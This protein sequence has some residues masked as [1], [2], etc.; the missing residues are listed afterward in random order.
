MVQSIVIVGAGIIGAATALQLAKAGHNVRVISDGR[1]DATTSAFGWINASFYLD[2]DH[3]HLRVA[4]IDAWR[5]L[6]DVVPLSVTW[7]GCLCWDMPEPK[8]RETY[9]TLRG[10]GYPVEMLNQDQI[11]LLEPSLREVPEMALLFPNEGAAHSA[12]I[13]K[14]LLRAAQ[15]VGAQILRNVTVKRVKMQGGRTIGVDTSDGVIAADQVILAAGTGTAALAQSADI[16]IP[17]VPR[18]AYIL[19]TSPQPKVLNHILA[20]PNGEIRQEPSGQLLMPVAV[21]H[22]ED[23]AEALTQT[24]TEAADGAIDRLRGLFSGMDDVQWSEVLRAERPVPVDNYPVVGSIGEGLYAA[25]L[26]SGITLGPLIAEL[27]AKEVTDGPDNA[28]AALLAAYRPQRF[29][30]A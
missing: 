26:H 3:H 23:A 27:I 2:D 9:N 10:F 20:A 18:P 19:R 22:Q 14:Q 25:V 29:T 21:S 8:L 12:D 1:P 30:S 6:T 13:P 4:G 15:G 24:P 16:T 11:R 5:R 28:T 17:M 7:D